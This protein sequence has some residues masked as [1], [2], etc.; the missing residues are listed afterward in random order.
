MRYQYL[1]I[2]LQGVH[3]HDYITPVSNLLSVLKAELDGVD[4]GK[5]ITMD[6]EPMKMTEKQ[7]NA[8]PGFEEEQ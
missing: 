3:G 5:K 1:K 4:I 2:K 7:Y 6:F 8:L